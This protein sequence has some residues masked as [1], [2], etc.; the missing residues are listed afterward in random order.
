MLCGMVG[1]M[2]KG[3]PDGWERRQQQ[4]PQT[5]VQ[6]ML[7]LPA[8]RPVESAGRT[9]GPGAFNLADDDADDYV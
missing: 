9:L 5:R 8:M 2:I 1:C 3:G 6:Q 7:P 4:T